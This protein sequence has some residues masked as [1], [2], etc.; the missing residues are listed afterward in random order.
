MK[1]RG[2]KVKIEDIEKAQ[3]MHPGSFAFGFLIWFFGAIYGIS[4]LKSILP[5]SLQIVEVVFGNTVSQQLSRASLILQLLGCLS[6][7]PELVKRSDIKSWE[8]WFSKW[9]PREE[10]QKISLFDFIKFSPIEMLSQKTGVIWLINLLSRFVIVS[11]MAYIMTE[12]ILRH[13][14]LF[15]QL[16]LPDMLF[17]IMIALL[18]YS[19]LILTLVTYQLRIKKMAISEYIILYEAGLNIIWGFMSLLVYIP[20]AIIILPI[21]YFLR[22]VAEYPIQKVIVHV[23]FWFIFMGVCLELVASY[24]E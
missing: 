1:S 10:S 6:V 9:K 24:L 21:Y 7:L 20:V 2:K 18:A 13:F 5:I 12:S 11:F 15:V 17:F 16:P 14:S 23:T 4:F 19:W 8:R 3:E 22:K